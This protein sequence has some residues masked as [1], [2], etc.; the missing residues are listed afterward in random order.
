ARPGYLLGEVSRN[1]FLEYFPVIFAV[2]TPL[3]VLILLIV[4]IPLWVIRRTRMPG[5]FMLVP[6]IVYFASAVSSRMNIGVRHIL[7]IYPFL[8]V[9][10][11]GSAAFFWNRGGAWAKRGLIVLA[12]WQVWSSAAIYPDYLTFFS[13]LAGGPKNGHRVALD[14]NLDWGQDLKGLKRWMD[15]NGVKKIDLLYFG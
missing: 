7:P 3:P 10:L 15:G 5:L 4:S 12:A 13:E 11:G 6:V 8:F 1:G 9:L 2:K 14:S